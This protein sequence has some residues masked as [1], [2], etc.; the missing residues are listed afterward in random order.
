MSPSAIMTPGTMPPRKRA[1]T[2]VLLSRAKTTKG[3]LGGMMGP[4]TEAEATRPAEKSSSKPSCFMPG[5]IIAPTAEAS[6]MAEPVTPP[7]SI[8]VRMVT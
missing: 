7:K 3:M 6:A 8:E 5:I 4:M 2:D 1:A